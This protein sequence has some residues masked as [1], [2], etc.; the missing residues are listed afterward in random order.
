MTPEKQ[1]AAL[2]ELDGCDCVDWG[3]TRCT[4]DCASRGKKPYLTSYDVIIPLI[5]KCRNQY[6]MRH[7]SCLTLWETPAQLCEATLRAAGKWE[8]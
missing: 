5:A 4:D 1:I 8:E 3:S 7:L 6:G 2:A